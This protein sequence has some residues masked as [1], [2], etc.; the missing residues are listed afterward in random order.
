[1]T[2]AQILNVLMQ[3]CFARLEPNAT[4]QNREANDGGRRG[5][6]L[7]SS[8]PRQPLWDG[9]RDSMASIRAEGGPSTPSSSHGLT[10][11]DAAFDGHGMDCATAEDRSL[12][13]H[14]PGPSPTSHSRVT[15]RMETLD[16][17][18]AADQVTATGA[19]TA[20]RTTATTAVMMNDEDDEGQCDSNAS[21]SGSIMRSKSQLV[22]YQ[23]AQGKSLRLRRVAPLLFCGVGSVGKFLTAF[24][25]DSV[26]MI[27]IPP[28]PLTVT[29]RHSHALLQLPNSSLCSPRT[30]ASRF[31]MATWTCKRCSGRGRCVITCG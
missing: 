22:A 28:I 5:S 27:C 15:G 2:H 1:M 7:A 18:P 23:S 29:H 12:M 16:G 30:E 3:P 26:V 8:A 19:Q 6:Q 9:P 13:Q 25:A 17:P 20:I 14:S 24:S 10:S 31:S 21:G 11:R 4:P